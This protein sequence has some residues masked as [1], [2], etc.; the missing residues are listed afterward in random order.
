M[1]LRDRRRTRSTSRTLYECI[2][3]P[4]RVT[5][6]C[7][8]AC[9]LRRL[10][11]ALRLPCA[12]RASAADSCAVSVCSRLARSAS[13]RS[14]T[15]PVL[16]GWILG[17]GNLLSFDFLLDRRLDAAAD[18]VDVR[19]RVEHV[20]P[21]CCSMSCR[22][23][24][25]SAASLRSSALRLRSAGRT[26]AANC[27]CCIASTSPTGRSITMYALPLRRPAADRAALR[28]LQR[29]GQQR[30]RL[31]SRPCRARGNRSCRST[32]DRS[33]R[34]ARTPR[35]RPS[36]CPTSS[37]ALISSGVNCDVLVLGELV[38]LDHV[39]ALDDRAVLDG[40]RTAA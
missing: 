31:R 19:G 36:A 2:A 3:S 23:S 30:V 6:V 29:L 5:G 18:L 26:S 38:A 24:L 15:L 10:L 40:R 11:D 35:S 25:S 9:G 17:H 13:I 39:V 12:G 1:V 33:T 27:S 7:A 22:A 8:L 20:A 4:R 32:P 28:F 34:S 14:M 21:V 16:S 37:S